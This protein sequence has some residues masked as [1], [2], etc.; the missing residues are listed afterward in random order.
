MAKPTPVI[1][2]Q[3][4]GLA[5]VTFPAVWYA[6]RD[7]G[8]PTVCSSSA[9]CSCSGRSS[10]PGRAS[11]A[12]STPSAATPKPPGGHR[13]RP[14]PHHRVHDQ[15]VHGRRGGH[16]A[17][18]PAPFGRDS[19]R[20]RNLLLIV[21]AAAVIGGTSLFGGDG[22][23]VSAPSRRAGDRLDPE[24]HGPPRSRLRH[25]VR[26][27]RARAARAVLVDAFAEAPP[28]RQAAST[29]ARR[30]GAPARLGGKLT[31]ARSGRA[32]SRCACDVAGSAARPSR[33]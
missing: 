7:R 29:E 10:R 12:T 1:L 20:G 9:S 31:V 32:L 33:R 22:R 13:R 16:H 19:T 2:L 3:I 23:V 25:E 8:V 14:D 21:I 6:N 5:V 4:A 11:A 27:H 15:R 28:C 30:I 26:H 17:G 24:R 18:L